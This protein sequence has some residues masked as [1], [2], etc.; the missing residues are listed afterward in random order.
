[1]S[2]GTGGTAGRGQVIS[3]TQQSARCR[4]YELRAGDRVVGG[5]RWRPGRRSAAQAQGQ[6]IGLVELTARRR[7]V[8]VTGQ[9]GREPLATVDR[10]RGGAVIHAI[11][12]HALRWEKT[13]QANRWAIREQGDVLLSVT[14]S[15]GLLRSSVRLVVE[16]TMPEETTVLLCLIASYLA[17]SELQSMADG[18]AAI[19]A[20]IAAGA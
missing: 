14:A 4:G 12:G 19:A 1:M 18:T 9:G 5:L 10:Q 17:L 2:D 6:G 3:L 11:E 15:Q 8:T 16:R 20:I 7:R 13:A